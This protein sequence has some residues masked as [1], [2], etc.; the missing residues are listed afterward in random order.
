MTRSG[1]SECFEFDLDGMRGD[2]VGGYD[3]GEGRGYDDLKVWIG[4]WGDTGRSIFSWL[5]GGMEYY[6]WTFVSLAYAVDI[7]AFL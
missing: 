2:R 7:L 1:V 3:V 6:L 4:R 5:K